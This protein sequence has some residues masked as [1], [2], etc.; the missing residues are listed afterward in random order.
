MVFAD[1]ALNEVKEALM[2]AGMEV[3]EDE[4]Y[5]EILQ[6]EQDAIDLGYPELR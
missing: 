6:M 1:P 2:L 4:D 3:L 5:R